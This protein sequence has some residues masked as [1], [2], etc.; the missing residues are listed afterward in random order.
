MRILNAGVHSRERCGLWRRKPCLLQG[1]K[2]IK[3]Q[4]IIC[5]STA[6]APESSSFL[7]LLPSVK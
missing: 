1:K 7:M 6:K 2:I 4:E 3:G 5:S